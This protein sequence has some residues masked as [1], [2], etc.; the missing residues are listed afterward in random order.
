MLQPVAVGSVE[1]V[2]WTV[3]LAGTGSV[4]LTPVAA[5]FPLAALVTVL[6]PENTYRPFDLVFMPC[7]TSPKAA[8]KWCWS[9]A[10]R[11]RGAPPPT[12]GAK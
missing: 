6:A 1:S 10:T 2:H 3:V 7:T 11:R 5:A 8:R 9:R 4:T 12:F